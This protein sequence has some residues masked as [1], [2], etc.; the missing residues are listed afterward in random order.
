MNNKDNI[1]K[2]IGDAMSSL[3][4]STRA[5]VRPFLMTRINARMSGRRESAWERAG[6]ILT[7]PAYV[8][9]GLCL[10]VGINLAV[11]L[12]STPDARDMNTVADQVQN[13][14][15]D[16]SSSVATL[17]YIENTESK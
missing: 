8:I 6:K 13:G 10:L 15:D 5:A 2:K 9:A 17:Y 3:D 1:E 7:R 4:G 11:V 16:Y 14:A 12:L